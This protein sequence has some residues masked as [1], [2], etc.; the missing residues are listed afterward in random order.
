MNKE[1][2]TSVFGESHFFFLGS[3]GEIVAGTS[4]PRLRAELVANSGGV[5]AGSGKAATAA[6]HSAPGRRLLLSNREKPGAQGERN[7]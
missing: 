4:R 6:L 7:T 2:H 5:G 1:Y 3:F